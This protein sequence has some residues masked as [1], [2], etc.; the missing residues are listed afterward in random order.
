M[1]ADK[2]LLHHFVKVWLENQ[3]CLSVSFCEI[4]D[5][6]SSFSSSI[7]FFNC[8]NNSRN[9]LVCLI[10]HVNKM[11]RDIC[12]SCTSGFS[13]F[14]CGKLTDSDLWVY[15]KI[16]EF[17]LSFIMLFSESGQYEILSSLYWLIVIIFFVVIIRCCDAS[18]SDKSSECWET[19]R[20]FWTFN[21]LK[22]RRIKLKTLLWCEWR[23]RRRSSMRQ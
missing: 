6:L 22:N 3:Q 12:T 21:Q 1:C 5:M 8:C 14:D 10:N 16:C 9:L 13:D 19:E 15:L 7:S 23:T 2:N 4:T 17:W 11:R 20:K 18:G